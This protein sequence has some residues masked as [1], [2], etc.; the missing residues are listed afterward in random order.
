MPPATMHATSVK[1]FVVAVIS[2]AV[3]SFPVWPKNAYAR[4]REEASH[5]EQS[6]VS[7]S[8]TQLHAPHPV[9][10]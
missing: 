7:R 4:N 5:L 8:A 6:G 3:D 9:P 10:H 2:T 1:H